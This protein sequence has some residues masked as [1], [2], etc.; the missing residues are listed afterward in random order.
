MNRTNYAV[1]A[2]ILAA[3]LALTQGARAEDYTYLYRVT[4]LRAAPGKL[5]DLMTFLKE[6]AEA[7]AYGEMGQQAPMIMRHSQGDQWDLLL[8]QP[9]TDYTDFFSPKTAGRRASPIDQWIDLLT[10]FR[11]DLFAYGPPIEIVSAAFGENAYYHIEMFAALPGKHGELL[12]QREI[13]NQYS[14]AIG[15]FANL[16]WVGDQ[17]SDVDV[18]TIGFYPS[19]VEF[20]TPSTATADEREQAALDAGFEGANFIGTYLR[21]LIASHHDTLATKVE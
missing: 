6:R 2:M 8:L 11:E 17:G 13:E 19:I 12:K 21:E 10:V 15:R 18:F 3:L 4:T 16:I 9:A 1:F 14:L 7:G 5:L 20:A